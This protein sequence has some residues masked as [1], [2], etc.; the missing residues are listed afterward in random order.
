MS[1]LEKKTLFHFF[2]FCKDYQLEKMLNYELT[3]IVNGQPADQSLT[4]EMCQDYQAHHYLVPDEQQSLISTP[5][6]IYL[7]SSFITGQSFENLVQHIHDDDPLSLLCLLQFQPNEKLLIQAIRM[8]F[9]DILQWPCQKKD[10]NDFFQRSINRDPVKQKS[11]SLIKN[12]NTG[13]LFWY[14]KAHVDEVTG[15]FNQRCLREDLF[16]FSQKV[17]DPYSLLF[18]DI[19]HF[20]TI[21]DQNGHIHGSYLLAEFAK[22]LRVLVRSSDRL[23]RYGGDEFI[24]LLP[25]T[26]KDQAKIVAE[27]IVTACQETTFYLQQNTQSKACYVQLSVSIGVA[28]YPEDGHDRENFLQMADKMLYEAKKTGRGKV[29]V[30]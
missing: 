7:I 4:W 11:F 29:V 10:W 15:L 30:F 20:K 27:R 22:V 23:Y 28:C 5:I 12:K 18:L 19:D 1:N 3:Q 9:D 24:V 8:G 13:P 26:K 16:Y 25:D 6:R 14:L 17:K 21:N 2:C